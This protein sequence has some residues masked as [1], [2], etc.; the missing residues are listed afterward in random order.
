ML[1][2]VLWLRLGTAETPGPIPC[3]SETRP[4]FWKLKST[5]THQ[6]MTW[7]WLA[8]NAAYSDRLIAERALN[9]PASLISTC[10]AWLIQVP[11]G[12]LRFSIPKMV[13][14]TSG[15]SAQ[16]RCTY[17]AIAAR[18][19]RRLL[20]PEMASPTQGARRWP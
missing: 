3:N 8:L 1:R 2:V 14:S 16:A 7:F 19:G 17:P 10:G 5:E 13:I 11:V 6:T 4:E 15:D 9:L 20:T 12:L 18:H